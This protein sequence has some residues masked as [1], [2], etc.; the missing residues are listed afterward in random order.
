M[1]KVKT[2][3]LGQDV[4]IVAG[5]VIFLETLKWALGTAAAFAVS[6]TALI[7]IIALLYRAGAKK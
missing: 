4:A 2:T 1:S 6:V 5:T 3:T 7:L